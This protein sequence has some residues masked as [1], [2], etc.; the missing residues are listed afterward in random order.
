MMTK[1]DAACGRPEPPIVSRWKFS[2]SYIVELE[3]H[4]AGSV[5]KWELNKPSETASVTQGDDDE[6]LTLRCR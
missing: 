6:K 5:T 1:E 3:H 2:K 4:W